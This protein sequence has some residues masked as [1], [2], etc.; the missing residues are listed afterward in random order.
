MSSTGP[1][2]LRIKPLSP[3]A[4]E[5]ICDLD[6]AKYRF[7]WGREPFLIVV[8]N[9]PISSFEELERLADL[10]QFKDREFLIV[11]LQPLL[12]GG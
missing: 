8:E 2:R 12:A 10:E 11:E 3:H 1:P 6:Q 5:D 7:N 9:Q 4:A